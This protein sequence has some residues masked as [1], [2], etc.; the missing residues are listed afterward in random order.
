MRVPDRPRPSSPERRPAPSVHVARELARPRASRRR[1]VPREARS[2]AVDLAGRRPS[3]GVPG[4][5]GRADRRAR[6]SRLGSAPGAHRRLRR[7]PPPTEQHARTARASHA[8]PNADAAPV[9]PARASGSRMASG[10]WPSAGDA[11]GRPAAGMRGRPARGRLPASR[12]AQRGSPAT[13]GSYG[14][15]VRERGP[16][17]R[18]RGE[19]GASSAAPTARS[20]PAGSGA[21]S[22]ISSSGSSA[23]MPRR[24]GGERQIVERSALEG[25]SV[26]TSRCEPTRSMHER[27]D[28]PHRGR[29]VNPPCVLVRSAPVWTNRPMRVRASSSRS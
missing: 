1:A 28:R 18:P 3:V 13:P 19:L 26:C 17:R 24:V 14:R 5:G 4:P 23:T 8:P 2:V 29:R 16:A 21:R 10:D 25:H 12:P 7:R 20:P 22:A 6:R 11:I 9:R 15:G 27:R